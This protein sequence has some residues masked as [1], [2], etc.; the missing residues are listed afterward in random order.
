MDK[1]FNCN[2]V[3][4]NFKEDA[5]SDNLREGDVPVSWEHNYNTGKTTIYIHSRKKLSE[6]EENAIK[7][8]VMA[9]C[10]PEMFENWLQQFFGQ[11]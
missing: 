7:G 8:Y 2:F 5:I 4:A 11:K 6:F 10:Y 3:L 9:R 1:L